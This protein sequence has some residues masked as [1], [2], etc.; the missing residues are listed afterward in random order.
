MLEKA[1]LAELLHSLLHGLDRDVRQNNHAWVGNEGSPVL[2]AR[3][4]IL[5]EPN[6][7]VEENGVQAMTIDLDQYMTQIPTITGFPGISL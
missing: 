2:R 6:G 5:L 7:I 4:N 3:L 1:F